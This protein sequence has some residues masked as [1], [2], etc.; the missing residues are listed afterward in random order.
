MKKDSFKLTDRQAVLMTQIF[1]SIE[2]LSKDESFIS[3]M[4]HAYNIMNDSDITEENED[5]YLKLINFKEDAID[6]INCSFPD[7]GH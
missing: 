7:S 3:K 2:E 5:E 4:E 1:D 6:I